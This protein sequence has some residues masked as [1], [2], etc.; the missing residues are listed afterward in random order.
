[1][2]ELEEKYQSLLKESETNPDIIGL[3]WGGARGKSN[4]FLTEYSD[5]DI[6]VVITDDESEE[7]IKKLKGYRKNGIFEIRVL[8]F[9]EFIHYADWGSKKDWDRYN[10][11]HNKAIIDKTGE[12]QKLMDEKGLLPE[13]IKKKI[14]EDSLDAYLNEIYR[15][16]KYFRDGLN[17]SAY[18]DATESLP[19]LMTALYALEGRIKPYNKYFEWELKNYPLGLLP[20]KPDEFITD[21]KHILET[22]D[23]KTQE[24]IFEGIKTIFI[25]RGF[26]DSINAWK[27]Y[28]FVGE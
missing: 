20:W 16:A 21:Y 24:K 13:D 9:S 25:D 14:I 10:F 17:F 26:T 1:M 15:S 28:Y 12:I 2:N 8:R 19:F 7:L 3:F 22:G 4:E 18:L 27:G 5:M 11:T 23:I 6:Y